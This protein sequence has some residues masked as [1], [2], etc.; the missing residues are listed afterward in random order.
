MKI[1]K[2]FY[3]VTSLLFTNFHKNIKVNKTSGQQYLD[4]DNLL[5]KTDFREQEDHEYFIKCM[6]YNPNYS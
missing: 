1:R 5:K 6:F 3:E 4:V 2:A